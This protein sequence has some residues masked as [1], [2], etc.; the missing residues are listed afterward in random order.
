LLPEIQLCAAQYAL[1][2]ANGFLAI[3]SLLDDS[4]LSP[5]SSAAIDGPRNPM[6]FNPSRRVSLAGVLVSNR[7]AISL[8]TFDW[9]SDVITSDT[10]V[11][12]TYRNTQNVR[13]FFKSVCGDHFKFDRPFLQWLKDGEEKTMGDAA[14]E[15]LRREAE[16]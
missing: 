13:R 6:G 7:G 1:F 12:A 5:S 2:E 10:P 14:K 8:G 9:H 11:T 3:E 16:T 15:W 4:D